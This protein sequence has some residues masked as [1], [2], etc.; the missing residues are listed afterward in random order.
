VTNV[1]DRIGEEHV[2]LGGHSVQDHLARDSRPVPEF[3]RSAVGDYAD[4]PIPVDRYLSRDWY[5]REMRDLWPKVWQMACHEQEIPEVG[6]R[7][8]YEVGD[9]SIIVVRSDTEEIRGFH[10]SCL[11]RANKLCVEAENSHQIRCPFHSWAWDLRGNN[12][13]VT[14]PWDFP[15]LDP[16]ELKLPEV[17]VSRWLGWVFINMYPAAAPLEEHLPA[18]ITEQF[19]RWGY[20]DRQLAV[21]AT[22]VFPLNWKA[23]M[24]AFLEAYHV[25]AVHPQ[26]APTTGDLDTQYDV[27]T[28]QVNR[29][30]TLTAV[31]GPAVG[32]DMTEQDLADDMVSLG[33]ADE[34]GN[35]LRI[36]EGERAR[37]VVADAMR[38]LMKA[39]ADVDMDHWSD[40]ELI[41]GI[42]Y[43]VFPNLMPWS[44]LTVPVTY[45]FLPYRDPD[46][47][48]MEV[49]WLWPA[50]PGT[51]RAR[52][53]HRVLSE[54]EGWSDV[55]EMGPGLA[56]ILDQDTVNLVRLQAGM[57]ASVGR[58]LRFSRYQESRIRHY[59]ARLGELLGES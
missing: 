31:P 56:A 12:T 22:K 37:A 15:D 13:V 54:D 10:N 20:Q 19:A 41:D 14:A 44:C 6:D 58:N 23:L 18:Q 32:Y 30:I 39:T 17:Q 50:K 3:M 49:Y 52:P 35:P 1:E 55:P 47:A 45:R 36:P 29:M 46:H 28:D 5:D 26:L 34:H 48:I 42:E 38:Q 25:S 8:L 4:A 9:H 53:V 57:K 21:R 33:V 59:H 40:C 2:R 27:L 7:V 24:D 11:H 16:A 43:F 51:P